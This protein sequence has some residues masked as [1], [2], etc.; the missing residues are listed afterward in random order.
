[1][2]DVIIVGMGIGGITAG[3]YAK[4]ANLNVLLIDKSAPGGLL[5]NIDLISNYPGF[6]DIKGPDLA[7][8]LF[9]QV[10]SIE[11]PYKLEEVIKIK[12]NE[13]IK[14]VITNSN[15]YQTKN[16]IIAT[17]T[18]PKYLGLDNEKE[19]LGRGLSTC[20]LCDGTFYKDKVIAVVGNGNSA[21]QESLYLAKLA[22]KVY[23]LNRKDSFKG[24]EYLQDKVKNK[25]N[26]E[27]KYN[28]S[29]TK[30]NEVNNKIESILLSNNEK[31]K[32]SGV[33]IYVG[34]K[35][36]SELVNGLDIINA[37]GR[38]M[39]DNNCE[40]KIKGLYAVG[41]VNDK[42]IYQLITAS[43]DGVIAIANITK[44]I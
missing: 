12:V 20:A 31:I 28:V 40:T 18:N 39:V 17:G 25:E 37:D 33:F 32:V 24:E 22:K 4:R 19:L 23:L 42:G 21:L 30:Y 27:I 16:I 6:I 43:N 15:T 36:N 1:M 8:K 7:L 26:I 2:Y 11:I 13:D 5:N 10:K 35:A 9:E 41:D 44:K 14:E 38:I 3:I 29:I 34:Y